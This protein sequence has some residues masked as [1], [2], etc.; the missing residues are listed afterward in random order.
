MTLV[1]IT[2]WHRVTETNVR[3]RNDQ[4]VENLSIL[5][6]N[7]MAYESMWDR[8]LLKTIYGMRKV[9]DATHIF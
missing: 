4:K 3:T 7:F 2:V 5:I 6:L 1:S 8:W 9:F